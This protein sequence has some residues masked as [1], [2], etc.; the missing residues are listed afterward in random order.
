M[1]K[2]TILLANGVIA[3]AYTNTEDSVIMAHHRE[4]LVKAQEIIS[5]PIKEIKYTSNLYIADSNNG[6]YGCR[7]F[8]LTLLHMKVNSL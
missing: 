1:E 5:G 8:V 6:E 3:A 2:V 7:R 4:L